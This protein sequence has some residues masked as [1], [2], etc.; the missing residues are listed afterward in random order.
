MQ[1]AK[2]YRLQFQKLIANVVS[3]LC[4]DIDPWWSF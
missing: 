3:K 2:I 4:L 1:L